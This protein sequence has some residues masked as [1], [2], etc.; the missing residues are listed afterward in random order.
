MAYDAR[1]RYTVLFGGF[2]QANK[3][4]P[5]TLYND[6][7]TYRGGAWT[8]LAVAGPP[9][10][11]DEAMAYDPA[12]GYVVLFGGEPFE[13]PSECGPCNQTWI[14]SAGT[15]SELNIAGP[16]SEYGATLAW[17]AA[18]GELILTGGFGAFYPWDGNLGTWAFVHGT[19]TN[20]WI[21]GPS[22]NPLGATMSYVPSA[23][24]LIL[25]G[26]AITTPAGCTEG[27]SSTW[28]FDGQWK[29]LSLGGPPG[30]YY[31]QM[32]FEPSA[33][34]G[35]LFGG[36]EVL[37]PCDGAP[38]LATLGDS[39]SFDGS[40]WQQLQISSPPARYS[41][42]LVYD[43][44]DGYDLLFGGTS[45][46][47]E[48]CAFPGLYLND[49]W[50]LSLGTV[51]PAISVSETPTAICVF[52]DHSCA[53]GT[54]SAEVSISVES[55]YGGYPTGVAALGEPAL[56]VLPW[57]EVEINQ[58]AP[59][60][61]A[62]DSPSGEAD[63]RDVNVT[64]LR[65]GNASGFQVDWSSDPFLDSLY[66]GQEWS[67]RFN[68]SVAGPPY[69]S[70]PVYACTTGPCLAAGSGTISGSFSSI[71]VQPLGP[72]SDVN[73]SLPYAN[74]S[75]D[76]PRVSPVGPS[77]PITSIPP[78][79]TGLPNPVALPSP[80]TIPT[81]VLTAIVVGVPTLSLSAAARAFSRRA[82]P[83]WFFVVVPSPKGSPWGIS[84]GPSPPASK[85]NDRRTRR[86]VGMSETRRI[87]LSDQPDFPV[88]GR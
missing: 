13:L 4:G 25:F 65:V 16:P 64:S 15:W 24:G 43:A 60:I 40:S 51:A 44:T 2:W 1:D 50:S 80:V 8:Q 77:Q 45:C 39:W 84:S 71:E 26:G 35:I 73:G 5:A 27:L 76:P 81:P 37:K 66:V 18:R 46:Q 42:A 68:I 52:D 83:E 32:A 62:C 41:S 67:V 63:Y 9:T 21:A 14:F 20:L 56:N 86:S 38:G 53:A 49:T 58:S 75:V 85:K 30:R 28:L 59:P 29:N 17:D 23:G 69:G 36:Y 34:E 7:W 87:P 3:S 55:E 12:D 48:S 78:P 54:W 57:D 22:P 72:D 31:G 70:V 6:T 10:R 79:P 19:W 47:G 88:G 74:I 82:L 11:W 61:V 33:G